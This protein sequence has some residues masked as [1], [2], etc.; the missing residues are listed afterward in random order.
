MTGWTPFMTIFPKF[1]NLWRDYCYICR[2]SLWIEF[3]TAEL[4]KRVQDMNKPLLAAAA[5]LA[6]SVLASCGM[7]K[8]GGRDE[9]LEDR[10]RY[11][12]HLPCTLWQCSGRMIFR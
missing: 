1:K 6:L 4:I 2:L 8:S 9:N 11:Q 7:G 10:S 3:R 5:V 12:G